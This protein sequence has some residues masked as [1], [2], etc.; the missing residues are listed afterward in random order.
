M[1]T[2]LLDAA[3]RRRS[4]P[5]C[6]LSADHKRQLGHTNLGITSIYLQGIDN[7]EIIDTVHARRPPV[8]PVNSTLLS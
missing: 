3:G 8:G 5:R 6:R 2:V 7:A 4:R 1:S